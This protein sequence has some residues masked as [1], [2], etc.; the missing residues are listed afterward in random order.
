MVYQI[1]FPRLV[2][3]IVCRHDSDF[4]HDLGRSSGADPHLDKNNCLKSALDFIQERTH[5]WQVTYRDL[6]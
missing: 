3:D 2:V 5:F 4:L 6:M 1:R